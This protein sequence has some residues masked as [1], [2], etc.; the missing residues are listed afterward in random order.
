MA[1]VKQLNY[2]KQLVAAAQPGSEAAQ[3]K[4]PA[5]PSA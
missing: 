2:A 3:T 1:S 4:A 5:A